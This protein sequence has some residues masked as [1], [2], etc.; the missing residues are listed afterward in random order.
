MNKKKEAD[1]IVSDNF[2]FRTPSKS[3]DS[4][5]RVLENGILQNTLNDNYFLES[6]YIAS[7]DLYHQIERY[8]NG[9]IN[10]KLSKK[11]EISIYKYFSRLCTRSTPFGLFAGISTGSFGEQ[12]KFKLSETRRRVTR[13]DMNYVCSLYL[14]LLKNPEF[15]T[16]LKFYPNTSL[17]QVGNQYRYIDFNFVNSR[18]VHRI[19]SIERS[20]FLDTLIDLSQQGKTIHDLANSIT[21]AEISF[22]DA[23][24]FV[25]E[26]IENQILISE[27]DPNVTGT[28]YFDILLDKIN[29]SNIQSDL[30][31]N[32]DVI[33]K[34]IKHIDT[35]TANSISNYTEIQRLVEETNISFKNNNLLQTD[36]FIQSDHAELNSN[37]KD[38][39]YEIINLFNRI[40]PT[41]TGTTLQAFKD[42]FIERYE[43]KE[44][45]LTQVL[46]L[47]IGLGFPVGSSSGD[48]NPLVD[49]IS[50]PNGNSS[51]S[52]MVN[53][54]YQFI[55][56][57]YN[58]HL[59]TSDRTIAITDELLDKFFSKDTNWKNLSDTMLMSCKLFN[60]DN[61][62][63]IRIFASFCG[64]SSA[65]NILGRFCSVSP[66]IS[67]IVKEVC[68]KEQSL[69]SD[70]IVAEIVHLPEARTGNILSRPHLREYE[71]PYLASSTLDR[72]HQIPINDITVSVKGNRVVIKSK[73]LNKE[74]LPKLTSAHNYTFN[75][76]PIYRFLCELQ[77]QNK[78]NFLGFTWNHLGNSSEFLPRLVYKNNIVSPATWF[79]KTK[80]LS[81]IAGLKNS[82][83]FM[84]K[85]LE[86]KAAKA[87]PD[88]VL[89]TEGDNE[90]Y[91]DLTKTICIETL[92]T[93][94]NG[95]PT[96]MIVEF[97]FNRKD[98]FIK[99]A[100]GSYTN[101][102]L[103][104]VQKNTQ[105]KH[106]Q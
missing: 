84:T 95:K 46:D 90:L 61:S 64:G 23:Q 45:P 66:E 99:G 101:E 54:Y 13:L 4:L 93:L 72:D 30:F 38:K 49:D 2:V 76:Q 73:K 82:P 21:D 68:D 106:G 36:L 78:R 85:W 51:S 48:I 63:D 16:L 56:E 11:M 47:D 74:I 39:I 102:F 67:N 32:I 65:G 26:L 75:A 18:R 24:E 70:K 1:Y 37:L 59:K 92:L 9:E 15:V 5:K 25:Y 52:I 96:L 103:F 88:D 12:A 35:S 31:N 29:A 28:I 50:I 87:I 14:N 97:L 71:I 62:N 94:T 40:T 42:A 91:L 60:D 104:I 7:P 86:F 19:T 69:N 105:E 43:D 58:Q 81:E 100:D 8:S 20:Q 34:K 79:I 83:Q 57:I 41:P 44:V 6:L 3:I 27:I 77:T 17:Y 80:E 33:N 98:Q 89:V 22:E 10:D 53:P 55:T